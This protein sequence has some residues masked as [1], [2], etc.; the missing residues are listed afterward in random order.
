MSLGANTPPPPPPPPPPKHRFTVCWKRNAKSV[1]C[2]HSKAKQ[3]KA[4]AFN[5]HSNQ[6]QLHSSIACS[7]DR[8]LRSSPLPLQL[9]FMGDLNWLWGRTKRPAQPTT[10]IQTLLV[11]S[12]PYPHYIPIIESTDWLCPSSMLPPPSSSSL[13]PSDGSKKKNQQQ[14]RRQPRVGSERMQNMHGS[15]REA[16]SY[17]ESQTPKQTSDSYSVLYAVT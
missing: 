1:Y 3:N 5:S 9:G 12:N 16:K 11:V 6:H 4:R 2:Y 15:D 7:I 8:L 14:Q 17:G 13:V 10:R